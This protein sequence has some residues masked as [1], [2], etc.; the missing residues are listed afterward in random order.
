MFA[1]WKIS[2]FILVIFLVYI[3]S[4]YATVTKSN[5]Y[6]DLNGNMIKSSYLRSNKKNLKETT[7]TYNT[8]N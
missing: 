4:A 7:Y 5:Y 8:K 2:A 3:S 1:K 6:Y